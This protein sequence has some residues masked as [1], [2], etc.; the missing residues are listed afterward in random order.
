MNHRLKYK[1][2]NIFKMNYGAGDISHD[3]AHTLR[4]LKN[5]KFIAIKETGD[6]DIIGPA[7]LFH[8][9]ICYSKNS[10]KSMLSSYESADFAKNILYNIDEYP[11]EK[12]NKVHTAI[13]EC[14]FS[15]GVPFQ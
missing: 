13:K 14:S 12:I 8:D 9:I 15:K 5:A 7:A 11:K 3:I 2:I 10:K 1:L 6:L 4:A